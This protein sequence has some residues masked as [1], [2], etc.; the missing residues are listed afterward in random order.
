[1][2]L[3]ELKLK[4]E[5][6]GENKGKFTGTIRY[7]DPAGEIEIILSPEAAYEYLRL[8]ADALNRFALDGLSQLR[9]A[10]MSAAI[11]L[12]STLPEPTAKPPEENQPGS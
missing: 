9:A 10:I 8:S 11:P 1:M 7:V 12:R 2:Q 6:W 5:T 3:D 4:R